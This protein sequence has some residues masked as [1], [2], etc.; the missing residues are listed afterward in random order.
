MARLTSIIVLT[1]IIS[2]CASGGSRSATGSASGSRN[3]ITS[4]QIEATGR[5]YAYEVVQQ[6]RPEWLRS[7][8][9]TS[10]MN[11]GTGMPVVFMNTVR[12]GNVDLLRSMTL[13]EIREIRYLTGPEATQLFGTGVSGGV[14][15]VILR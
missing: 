2:A 1:I 4:Q 11:S 6:L 5:H 7:R 12:H 15:Q 8:G 10:I 13:P 14:I 9:A 3:V